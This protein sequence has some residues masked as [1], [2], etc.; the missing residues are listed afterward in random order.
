MIRI[1]QKDNKF[2]KG[3]FAVIIG[4]AIV[5][6]VITLVPGIFTDGT[7]TDPGTFASVRTPGFWGHVDGDS[8]AIKTADVQRAAQSQMQQQNLPPFYLQF[9]MQRAGQIQVERAVLKHEADR[10]GLQVSDEDLKNFLQS[11][12]YSQ[13]LFP[14]GT[15]IGR[16]QYI[17]FVETYFR[18]PVDDFEA[19]VK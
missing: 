12:P 6:M 9:V 10:L 13:Y 15:F 8:I 14:G 4:A 7:T 16:D 19:E 2:T 18:L 11:G 1:L 3:L 5:T 17:N